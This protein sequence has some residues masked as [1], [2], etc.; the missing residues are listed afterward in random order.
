MNLDKCLRNISNDCLQYW[1]DKYKN[2]P[3]RHFS[4]CCTKPCL[5]K[6][7]PWK[8]LPPFSVLVHC[9]SSLQD[10][11][12]DRFPKMKMNPCKKSKEIFSSYAT[13]QSKRWLLCTADLDYVNINVDFTSC[14][15]FRLDSQFLFKKKIKNLASFFFFFF[16][17]LKNYNHL[18]KFFFIFY[19]NIKIFD[20]PPPHF[21]A[22]KTLLFFISYNKHDMK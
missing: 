9:R 21:M 17:F 15:C 10:W 20:I 2:V 22:R 1:C 16:H 8:H 19:L 6:H 7:S 18:F 3:G 4:L 5:Q 12:R 14:L 13:N 11:P